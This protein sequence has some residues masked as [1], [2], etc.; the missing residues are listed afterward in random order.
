MQ[1]TLVDAG[2]ILKYN[3]I[4]EEKRLFELFKPETKRLEAMLETLSR[5]DGQF[6]NLTT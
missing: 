6:N 1:P 3:K 4:S 5:Y 2:L